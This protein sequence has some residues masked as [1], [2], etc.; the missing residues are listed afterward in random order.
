[1][2]E[3]RIAVADGVTVSAGMVLPA[4]FV[5]GTAPAV[6]LAHGA[7][8]DRRDALLGTVQARL[9]AAGTIAVAF[10]FPYR[11]R[12]RWPPDRRPVLDAAYGRVLDAI[13]ADA[14]LAVPHVVVGGRSLGGRVASHLAAAGA[15]VSGVVCLAFPLHPPR[16][17]ATER[18]AHLPQVR[19]PM[20]FVQGTRDPLADWSLMQRVVAPL[21]HV[22]VHAIEDADHS[23]ALPRRHGRS[24]AA[25]HAEI[26]E[27]VARWVTL[28]PAAA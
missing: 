23:F 14:D 6:L 10:N 18:A 1:V 21:E 16:R 25:V 26:A 13:R 8:S 9:A 12:G 17:P 2:I 7:G 27:V 15:P 28:L 4:P 20:L 19:V 22:T 24:A 11:E 5:P 3:R